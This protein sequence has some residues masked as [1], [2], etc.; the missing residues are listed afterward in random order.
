MS[1]RRIRLVVAGLLVIATSLVPI[2][3]SDA[4]PAVDY[5]PYNSVVG[6]TAWPMGSISAQFTTS[7]PNSQAWRD[8]LNEAHANWSQAATGRPPVYFYTPG[9]T[10]TPSVPCAYG[11][12]WNGLF[13]G[14]LQSGVLARTYYCRQYQHWNF[15]MVFSSSVPWHTSNTP[16]TNVNYDLEG[17]ATHEWAHAYGWVGDFPDGSSLCPTPVVVGNNLAVRRTMCSPAPTGFH[18]QRTP[19]GEDYAPMNAAFP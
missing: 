5:F 15:Q 19:E 4:Y 18:Q 13:Y 2:G 17:I 12:N 1:P 7:L 9:T 16:G 14:P 3:S 10:W 8:R 6:S 11:D